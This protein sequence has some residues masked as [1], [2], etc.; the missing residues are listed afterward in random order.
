[1]IDNITKVRSENGE[2]LANTQKQFI[3]D[4]SHLVQEIDHKTNRTYCYIYSHPNSYEPLAQLEF[5]KNSKNPTACYYYHTD[6]IG[7]PREL[8]D[9]Q[10]R[11]CWYGDYTGWGKLKNEY[12]L[13]ENIHQPFRLQNQ[14]S[15][16]ETG[17]HYNFF[18]YYEPNV[19]R[20]T[21]LDP[22][23]LAG[24]ENL[25]RF[26]DNVQGWGDFLGL[27]GYNLLQKLDKQLRGIY[28]DASATA[29][30]GLAVSAEYAGD[31]KIICS[32]AI[33][34]GASLDISG[35]MSHSFD[36]KEMKNGRLI[37]GKKEDGFFEESCGTIK[38]GASVSSCVGSNLSQGANPYTVIKGGIGAGGGIT[39]SIGYQK[40]IDLKEILRVD[41]SIPYPGYGW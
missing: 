29:G 5:A 23:G 17:L 33:T 1:M 12:A 41:P 8:T 35:G 3:W 15:D 34:N 13:V 2:I 26:A 31:G 38:A 27:E 22:I 9:E 6:Q 32:L 28:V 19:G 4:G 10:G 36:I 39:Q 16:E 25:Y 7:V 40:T 21:Q 30:Y 37:D 18:R 24:G 11:L 20:F 14:Y